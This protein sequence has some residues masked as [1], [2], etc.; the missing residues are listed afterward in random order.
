MSVHVFELRPWEPVQLSLF[1]PQEQGTLR[2]AQGG[3]ANG[4]RKKA[5]V[6]SIESTVRSVE[7][8]KRVSDAVDAINNRYGE[9]VVTPALMMDMQGT[10]LDRIAFG[11]V[12]DFD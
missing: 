6:R 9:F 12:R 11:Q 8:G 1:E 4:E 3:R 5:A 2:Q 10:I 7:A